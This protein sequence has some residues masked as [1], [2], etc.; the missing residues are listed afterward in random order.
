MTQFDLVFFRYNCCT[1]HY[2][3]SVRV[4]SFGTVYIN[5]TARDGTRFDR[6]I[7]VRFEHALV[8]SLRNKISNLRGHTIFEFENMSGYT[9]RVNIDSHIA[10]PIR[11]QTRTRSDGLP[12][13]CFAS[14]LGRL[15]REEALEIGYIIR[16]CEAKKPPHIA[17]LLQERI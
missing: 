16:F 10:Y 14:T 11:P 1:H 15:A 7:R 4:Q 9:P 3:L 6:M 13:K 12:R 5:E 17:C 8:D 2:A